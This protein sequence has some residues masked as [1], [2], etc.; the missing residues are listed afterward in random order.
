MTSGGTVKAATAKA[1]RSVVVFALVVTSASLATSS[2]RAYEFIGCKYA[3]LGNNLKWEN[4]TTRYA[5]SNPAQHAMSAWNSSSSQF[6]FAEVTSGA[7]L[8]LTDGNFGNISVWGILRDSSGVDPGPADN[9]KCSSGRWAE[10]NS[11]WLNRYH[12]DGQPG[13][14]KKSVY[15]HEVGHAIGLAHEDDLSCVI[16]R[17]YVDNFVFDCLLDSPTQD[18]INGANALY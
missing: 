7:N 1:I 14:V 3:G 6:N 4:Q 8:R 13:W 16:M 2:A 18:D 17:T 10:A 15:V 11:A 9:P 12:L 5:Y